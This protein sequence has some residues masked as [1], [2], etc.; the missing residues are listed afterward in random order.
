MPL[1]VTFLGGKSFPRGAGPEARGS[2][3]PI[4]EF[5]D[6]IKLKTR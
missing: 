6:L 5:L 1:R 4:A 2:R 3:L